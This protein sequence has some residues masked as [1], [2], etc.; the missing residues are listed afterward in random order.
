MRSEESPPDAVEVDLLVAGVVLLVALLTGRRRAWFWQV[1]TYFALAAAAIQV[2][3]SASRV[4]GPLGDSFNDQAAFAAV[5]LA[6]VTGGA[7]LL[8]GAP[9][10]WTYRLAIVAG[11][12]LLVSPF[13]VALAL[14][15]AA[16]VIASSVAL[17]ASARATPQRRGPA[18][19]PL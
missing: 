10:P 6:A 11:T 15:G 12:V 4:F 19:E 17:V 5:V 3:Y 14:L 18:P 2:G 16:A 13:G 9:A 1:A 8:L 7:S